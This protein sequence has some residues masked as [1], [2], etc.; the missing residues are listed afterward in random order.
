M[1]ALNVISFM[2]MIVIFV[3]GFIWGKKTKKM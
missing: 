3:L 2:Y 1:V